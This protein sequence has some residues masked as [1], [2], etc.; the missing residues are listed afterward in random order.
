[1]PR[2]VV[3][4]HESSHAVHFDFM[5]EAGEVLKTW[6]LPQPPQPGVEMACTALADHRLAY[7]D[8]EGPISGDRGSVTRWDFGQYAVERQTATQWVVTLASEKL[9]GTA[10]LRCPSLAADPDKWFFVIF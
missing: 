3:L 9:N 10:T 1:M 4:C 2:F 7:L 8:Y 5:L 6:A